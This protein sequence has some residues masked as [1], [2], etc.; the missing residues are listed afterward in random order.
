MRPTLDINARVMEPWLVVKQAVRSAD[1]C[2]RPEGHTRTIL[3]VTIVLGAITD[4]GKSAV[5]AADRAICFKEGST[6]FLQAT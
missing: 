3:A 5:I 1:F 6:E 4:G 2:W